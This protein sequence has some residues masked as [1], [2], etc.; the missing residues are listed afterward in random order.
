MPNHAADRGIIV[1]DLDGTICEH[2]Y[3]AFGEPIAGAKEA[4]QRLKAAGFWIVIH[5][6]RTASFLTTAE[7][8]APEVNSPEA[9]SAFLQRHEIPYDE[10][11]MHDKPL[12][13]AYIDDRGMR[14]TGN[15]VSSN[16]HE[17]VETLLPWE[18]RP[19]VLPRWLEWL[20]KKCM[21]GG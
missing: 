15:R 8:F 7:E 10:I 2:R 11:W 5:T 6:V 19:T 14:V 21:S 1:V 17:V 18:A 9:V 13:V 20:V 3:P 12:A 16:W 4:L